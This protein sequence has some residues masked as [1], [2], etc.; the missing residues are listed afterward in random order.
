MGFDRRGLL[1]RGLLRC[2]RVLF[3][4]IEL[5]LADEFGFCCG[6]NLKHQTHVVRRE[7]ALVVADHELDFGSVREGGVA[8]SLGRDDEVRLFGE[9]RQF[10]SEVF[11]KLLDGFG[12]AHRPFGLEVFGRGQRE[13]GRNGTVRTN[14]LRVHVPAGVNFG[15]CDQFE[16]AGVK[17][18]HRSGPRDGLK[19][20][21]E[22]GRAGQ[23]QGREGI[24]QT[25]HKFQ[26]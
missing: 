24:E 17:S 23:Q 9:V 19:N 7:A 2:G 16:L 12:L 18:P 25:I 10:H 21:G 15:S 1:T 5:G 13:C 4:G 26:R 22:G 3:G 11:V 6:W 8:D 14:E 20:L